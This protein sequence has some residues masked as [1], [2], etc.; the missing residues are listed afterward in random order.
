[1]SYSSLYENMTRIFDTIPEYTDK[2]LE[3]TIENLDEHTLW[4][5]LFSNYPNENIYDDDTE[6]FVNYI[7][8]DN[9]I[10]EYNHNDMLNNTIYYDE[11]M[12]TVDNKNPNTEPTIIDYDISRYASDEIKAYLFYLDVISNIYNSSYETQFDDNGRMFQDEVEIKCRYYYENNSI[13]LFKD[14][15]HFPVTLKIKRE[16]V[17]GKVIDIVP[18]TTGKHVTNLFKY[19][20]LDIMQHLTYLYGNDMKVVDRKY[21]RDVKRFF[22]LCRLKLMYFVIHSL[23]L[24]SI[25]YD[26]INY[27]Q[28]QHDIDEFTREQVYAVFVNFKQS[29]MNMENVDANKNSYGMEI[30]SKSNKLT[31]MNNS[32]SNQT[33][34]LARKK[35]IQR[36]LK[37]EHKRSDYINI[38]AKMILVCT[39]FISGIIIFYKQNSYSKTTLSLSLFVIIALIY[40]FLMYSYE[41]IVDVETFENYTNTNPYE[42]V[43]EILFEIQ[44]SMSRNANEINKTMVLKKMNNDFDKYSKYDDMMNLNL[45]NANADLEVKSLENK[46]IQA[47]TEYILHISLLIPFV[48]L[49][50]NLTNDMVLSFA[51]LI[52]IFGIVTFIYYMNIFKRVRTRARQYYWNTISEPN[53]NRLSPSPIIYL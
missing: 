22:S 10:D 4:Q 8:N 45:K 20:Q 6:K 44:N 48:I 19:F 41:H 30:M 5:I 27:A 37:Q 13:H 14:S 28:I 53:S 7:L 3:K 51:S 18:H 43:Y 25:Q 16:G 2:N 46:A 52:I 38:A 49:I 31:K 36:I 35:K 40:A 24:R 42:I 26:D 15:D 33:D 29:I 23:K 1:M 12:N 50:Y 17:E 9:Y 32:I 34:K 39:L 11:N 47:K 21:F